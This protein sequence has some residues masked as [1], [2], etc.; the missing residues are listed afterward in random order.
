MR[1]KSLLLPLLIVA[2]SGILYVSVVRQTPANI[3][4]TAP[5]AVDVSVVVDDGSGSSGT[6]YQII[7]LANATAF[8]ALQAAA[9][10]NGFA[11]D[12]DP[13]GQYGVFV[14]GIAGRAGNDQQFWIY[15]INGVEGQVAADQA[16]VKNGDTV[17]WKYTTSSAN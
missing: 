9:T 1:K 16:P 7:N 3:N 2:L 4:A 12:Y 17:T 14:N 6:T 8:S 11:L 5:G 10:A 15:S 13:P